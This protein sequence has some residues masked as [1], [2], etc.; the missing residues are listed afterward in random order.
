MRYLIDAYAWIEYLNG[1]SKGK[2]VKEILSMQNEIFSLSETIA[3]VVSKVKRTEGNA[4]IAYE[5]VISNSKIFSITP[6]I[7][8]EAGLFH[9]ETRKKI[10]DFGLVDSLLF[11][12]ARKM[13]AKILTGDAHF[14]GFKEAVLI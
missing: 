9:A 10:K 7:A 2:K 12:T 5:A 6:A 8:K 3:E 14:K 11:T 4:E 1:S 13:N